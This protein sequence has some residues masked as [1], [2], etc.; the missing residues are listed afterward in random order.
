MNIPTPR[1]DAVKT[2]SKYPEASDYYGM[3]YHANQ[4]ERELV[5]MT[6]AAKQAVMERDDALA[7]IQSVTQPAR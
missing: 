7:K 1:T 6:E 4:L 3:L 5:T 2:T